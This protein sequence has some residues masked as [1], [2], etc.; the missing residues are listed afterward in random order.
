MMSLGQ[1]RHGDT[2]LRAAFLAGDSSHALRLV[3]GSGCKAPGDPGDRASLL[4][5]C[6]LQP[7]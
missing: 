3:S 5:A 6:I 4:S 7:A 1:A 2:E